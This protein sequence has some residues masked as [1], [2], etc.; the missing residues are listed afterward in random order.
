MAPA[1]LFRATNALKHYRG[2]V[3]P[4]GARFNAYMERLVGHPAFKRTC[5]TEQ[6]YLDSYERSV[7]CPVCA[8]CR[9]HANDVYTRYAFNRP[10][11]SQVADAIN[12][13]TALP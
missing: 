2:F 4:Q 11:T 7:Y 9:D 12:T 10:N 3:M 6:L 1:G 8:A 5:S 13:G